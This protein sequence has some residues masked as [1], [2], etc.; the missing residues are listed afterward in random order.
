MKWQ[1]DEFVK[2]ACKLG[3]PFGSKALLPS[4]IRNVIDD[5][6]NKNYKNWQDIIGGRIEWCRMWTK[7]LLDLQKNECELHTACHP[8]VKDI[9]R[10][11]RLLLWQRVLWMLDMRMRTSHYSCSEALTL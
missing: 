1:P 6:F 4:E 3:H 5:H 11:K 8:D 7:D 10:G 9:I 2:E